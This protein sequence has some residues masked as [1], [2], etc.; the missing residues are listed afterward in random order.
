MCHIIFKYIEV[1]V[2]PGS[3]PTSYNFYSEYFGVLAG[4]NAWFEVVKEG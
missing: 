2:L 1:E 4:S 3:E